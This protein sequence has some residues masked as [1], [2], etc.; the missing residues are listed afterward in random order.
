MDVRITRNRRKTTPELADDRPRPTLSG[1]NMA[2]APDQIGSTIHLVA[3]VMG[4]VHG[5]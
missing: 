4:Q 2:T 1:P 5:R 3:E